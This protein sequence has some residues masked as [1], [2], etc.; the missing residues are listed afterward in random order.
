MRRST[1]LLLGLVLVAVPA[2]FFLPG[3]GM[4]SAHPTALARR[5]AP[6][7][8]WYY[9]VEPGDVISRIA[10][11]QL[12]TFKRYGEVLALNPEVKP[13]Q[14]VPGTVLRMPPRE[15][16]SAPVVTTPDVVEPANPRLMLI[17]LG[18]LLVLLLSVLVVAGR[19]E[20]G[21]DGA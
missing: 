12:G 9:R 10:E 13:R 6:A 4:E 21:R 5:A 14:L 15:G 2:L 7:E 20:R 1:R 17:A 19:I 8:V 3:I 18:A 16:P 11:Q